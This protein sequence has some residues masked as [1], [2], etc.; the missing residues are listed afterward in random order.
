MKK[1]ILYEFVII[2]LFMFIV[3]AVG[4]NLETLKDEERSSEAKQELLK[5]GQIYYETIDSTLMLIYS[6]D[7]VNISPAEEKLLKATKTNY[8]VIR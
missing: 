5:T 2:I 8:R 4:L 3:I 7:E 6:P 1:E